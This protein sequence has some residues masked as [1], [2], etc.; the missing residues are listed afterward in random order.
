MSGMEEGEYK[1][2][3][4]K[5]SHIS[6]ATTID[7]FLL[8]LQEMCLEAAAH[9]EQWGATELGMISAKIAFL[10][11]NIDDL[12]RKKAKWQDAYPGGSW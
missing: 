10:I 12:Y 3:E 9:K 11:G 2:S 1:K 5:A 6:A 8:S 4:L 7:E